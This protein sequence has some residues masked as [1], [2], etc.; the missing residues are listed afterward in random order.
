MV[1]SN[2][3][4]SRPTS[5][6]RGSVLAEP[7]Y[8]TRSL[9]CVRLARLA[10]DGDSS[11]AIPEG[12]T[13]REFAGAMR[14][15]DATWQPHLRGGTLNFNDLTDAELLQKMFPESTQTADHLDLAWQEFFQRFY[16]FLY[17]MVRLI[18]GAID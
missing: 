5:S 18:V 16:P 6:R 10:L 8:N 2:R 4:T 3:R 13:S 11:V 1:R 9:R 7:A 15:I 17:K 12:L 14:A